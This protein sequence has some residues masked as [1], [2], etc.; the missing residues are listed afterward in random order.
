[1]IVYKI[2]TKITWESIAASSD[3]WNV[4]AMF[5]SDCVW[6]W[7]SVALRNSFELWLVFGLVDRI[8][9]QRL[10]LIGYPLNEKA[11]TKR[12]V[13]G[14]FVCSHCEVHS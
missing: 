8:A 12:S 3:T 2:C 6:S 4:F 13:L 14:L 9:F 1:M 5:I 7:M 11:A 10:L